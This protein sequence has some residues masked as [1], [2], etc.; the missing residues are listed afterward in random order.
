[1]NE[2]SE[3][4]QAKITWPSHQQFSRQWEI[5]QDFARSTPDWTPI[6]MILRRTYLHKVLILLPADLKRSRKVHVHVGNIYIRVNL[7]TCLLFF[8]NRCILGGKI[9]TILWIY[10]IQVHTKKCH[11]Y[12]WKIFFQISITTVLEILNRQ[13]YKFV[14]L[15]STLWSWLRQFS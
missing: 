3:K 9:C 4:I 13:L 7:S 6:Q 5:W 15:N 11:G 8:C 2:K 10:E 12:T 1:M 14:F